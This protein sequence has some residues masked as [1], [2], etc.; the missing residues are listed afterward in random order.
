MLKFAVNLSMLFQDLPLKERFER[1]GNAD[2]RPLS[3]YGPM[4]CLSRNLRPC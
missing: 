2:S 4:S 3:S 1:A